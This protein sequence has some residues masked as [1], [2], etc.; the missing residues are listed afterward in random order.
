MEVILDQVNWR[1]HENDVKTKLKKIDKEM[2]E[3]TQRIK[4]EFLRGWRKQA[5]GET[6]S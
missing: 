6:E 3:L 5:T 4:S 1:F 2:K